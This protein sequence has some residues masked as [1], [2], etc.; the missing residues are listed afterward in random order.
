MKK[1]LIPISVD[2]KLFRTA[3][4]VP[5]LEAIPQGYDSVLFF[6]A[7][8]LQLYNKVDQVNGGMQLAEVFNAFRADQNFLAQRRTW[9][10][11]IRRTSEFDLARVPWRVI[12]ASEIEDRMFSDIWRA[13]L[14]MYECVLPF[15]DDVDEAAMKWVA[16]HS[17]TRVELSRRLSKMFLLE[18]IAMNVRLRVIE[19]VED[20]YYAGTTLLPLQKLYRGDYGIRVADIAGVD[21]SGIGFR[22]FS[23]NVGD[24]SGSV[25]WKQL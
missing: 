8:F 4:F 22:F 19:R 10:M 21:T 12:G 18:E 17:K 9:I 25:S 3:A 6:V 14:M 16:S 24:V 1:C 11:K 13:V 23:V 5:L 7:D 20:E 2:S 15:R